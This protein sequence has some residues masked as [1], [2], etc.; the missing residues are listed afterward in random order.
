M[1]RLWI[2]VISNCMYGYKEENGVFDNVEFLVRLFSIC[3]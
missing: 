2:G 1:E 3:L